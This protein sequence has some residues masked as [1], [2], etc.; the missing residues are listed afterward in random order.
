MVVGFVIAL[1]LWLSQQNAPVPVP[2]KPAAVPV[3]A[4]EAPASG[5]SVLASPSAGVAS[6]VQG[7][8]SPTIRINYSSES[9]QMA[10]QIRTRLVASGYTSVY[11]QNTAIQSASTLIIYT[12][13]VP[14]ELRRI[15]STE[16]Q[17]I[18]GQIAVKEVSG[19]VT[20]VVI[21]LRGE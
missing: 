11:L 6:E 9:M 10:N 4:V 13:N 14:Y 16:V 20:D 7:A 15:I 1:F 5:S 21:T 8:V 3:Q 17:G 2:P 19:G 18:A 12:E